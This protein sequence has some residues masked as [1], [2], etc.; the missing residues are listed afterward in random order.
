MPILKK[1]DVHC[2]Y[3]GKGC[4]KE[5]RCYLGRELA[6]RICGLHA[7][8]EFLQQFDKALEECL[9]KNEAKWLGCQDLTEA[10][11]CMDTAIY[12]PLMNYS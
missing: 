12:C 9:G 11:L 3:S 4:I 2:K 10:G 7:Y 1:Y 5:D 6:R 8:F